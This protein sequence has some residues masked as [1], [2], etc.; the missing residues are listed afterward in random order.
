[1]TKI[2]FGILGF[3]VCTTVSNG[4]RTSPG[5]DALLLNA[6][7]I[8]QGV[9][10]D[11]YCKPEMD[12]MSVMMD[13]CVI[14]LVDIKVLKGNPNLS[15]VEIKEVG[16]RTPSGLVPAMDTTEALCFKH[17]RDKGKFPTES[18]DR[19]FYKDYNINVGDAV[20]VFLN[21]PSQIKGPPPRLGLN[22]SWD[23]YTLA[24]PFLGVIT[25]NDFVTEYLMRNIKKLAT[26]KR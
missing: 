5:L 24:D 15:I 19:L 16:I 11:K 1:L 6:E 25:A 20:I 7:I 3:I 12:V 4:Q 13:I 10:Y 14:S 22:Q 23:V 26:N 18:T 21:G 2:L 9:C 8:V 17:I